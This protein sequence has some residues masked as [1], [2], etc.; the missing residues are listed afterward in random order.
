MDSLGRAL[1]HDIRLRHDWSEPVRVEAARLPWVGSPATQVERRLLERLGGEVARATSIVRYRPGARFDAHAHA[2]GEEFWVLE[3]VFSDEEGHYPAGTW[4]RNPPGSSHAPWSEGGCTIFVK[5]RYQ[6]PTDTARLRIEA[7]MRHTAGPGVQARSLH[8]WQGQSTTVQRWAPGTQALQPAAL[9]GQE[10]LV[11]EGDYRDERG[12]H[13]PLT[14]L[15]EPAAP[16]RTARTESGCLLLVKT[17]HL[18]TG[19]PACRVDSP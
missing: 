17:G 16:A 1:P 3:G 13:G 6:H 11:I 10:I 14:W 2:L 8:R 12:L 19:D 4:V 7:A 9:E 15:R 18:Q 5:L